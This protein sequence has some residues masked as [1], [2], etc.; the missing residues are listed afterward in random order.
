MRIN[1]RVWLILTHRWLGIALGIMLV[2]WAVS[3]VVLTY[4]GVPHLTA[5]E[6]LGRLPLLDLG[7]VGVSPAEA[8]A[9]VEGTPL[10][11]RVAMLGERPVYRINTGQV[12][13]R[14]T[15]VYADTGEVFA[16]FDADSAGSGEAVMR[17]D[18]LGR[19]LG[20]VGYELHTLFFFRQRSWWGG[21]LQI[22][23]WTEDVSWDRS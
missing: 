8:A 5:G 3:G 20:F 15:L 12:F 6:R 22:L 19:A 21:L 9:R 18:R 7:R 14:W 1:W 23:F 2:A 11:I 4:C 17:T 16:G 13:G 10:R